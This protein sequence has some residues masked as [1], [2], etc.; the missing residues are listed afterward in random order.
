MWKHR[1]RTDFQLALVVMF[2]AITVLGIAPFA[3]RHFL[4]GRLLAGTVDL[5]IVACVAAGTAYAWRTGRATFAATLVAVAYTLGCV[6]V[7]W[8]AGLP[9]LLW[10]YP[11]ITANFLLASRRPAFVISALAIPLVAVGSG[12]LDTVAHTVTF[13]TTAVVVGVF[14]YVFASRAAVQRSHLEQIAMRDP[15]TGAGNRRG[16][17]AE[18]RI[19]IGAGARSGEPP[20]LLVLDIDHFKQVNDNH[21]HDAGDAVLVQLA[22]LVRSST[23]RDDR[24]FRIGG[25]EFAVLLPGTTAD[26]LRE[27]AEKLRVAVERE[28]HCGERAITIS[29]GATLHRPGESPADWLARADAA[30]YRAKRS[31]RNRTVLDHDGDAHEAPAA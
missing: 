28:I 22:R 27:I 2:G 7:A 31:G 6:V 19:A 26:T 13:V 1:I 8:L 17:D 4:A 30:M 20:G 12:V 24:F 10:I 15:L 23:R 9:G 16:M 11:A 14:S 18:L 25:E 29:I 5:L 21:G 3:I